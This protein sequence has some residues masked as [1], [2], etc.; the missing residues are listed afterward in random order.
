MY[1]RQARL[2][3]EM[4]LNPQNKDCEPDEPPSPKLSDQLDD[5]T[6]QMIRIRQNA[7]KNIEAAQQKQKKTYD[8]KH[9]LDKPKYKV[10]AMV[11]LKNSKKLSKKGSKMEQNWKGPYQINEVKTKGTFRLCEVDKKNPRVLKQL[12]NIT[13]LKLFHTQ[14]KSPPYQNTQDECRGISS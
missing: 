3:I 2:P 4:V 12:V 10:G 5:W 13:R 1:G 11:L 9:S 8:A 6:S 14:E 7:L